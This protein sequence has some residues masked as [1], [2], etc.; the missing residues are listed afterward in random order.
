[1]KIDFN[2]MKKAALSLAIVIVLNVF[3]NVSLETFYPS[4]D[5]YD[6]CP[7]T[8][9]KMTTAPE[10]GAAEL[11]DE[12]DSLAYDD[13]IDRCYDDYNLA[14]EERN[15]HAFYILGGLGLLSLVIGLAVPMVSAVSTGLMYGGILSVLIGTMGYWPDMENYEQ[16]IVSAV[17]LI[18]LIG[19]GITKMRDR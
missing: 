6:Y 17:A 7:Y 3:F 16:L 8:S 5:Y 2:I 1:M 9:E 10:E 15:Y 19:L 13:V 14:R 18:L 12:A 11:S 4:P